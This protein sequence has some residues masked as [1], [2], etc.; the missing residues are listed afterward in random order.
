MPSC[1]RTSNSAGEAQNEQAR[2][3]EPRDERTGKRSE[4]QSPSIEDVWLISSHYPLRDPLRETPCWLTSAKSLHLQQAIRRLQAA[5]NEVV[6]REDRMFRIG[7]RLTESAHDQSER[8]AA[9]RRQSHRP[10]QN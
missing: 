3:P 2:K 4:F 10:R 8:H 6:W 1:L 5:R 7:T 9:R